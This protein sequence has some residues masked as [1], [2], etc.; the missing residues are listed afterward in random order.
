M[1]LIFYH[2]ACWMLYIQKSLKLIIF[3]WRLKKKWWSMITCNLCYY[4]LQLWKS[5]SLLQRMQRWGKSSSGST[6]IEFFPFHLSFKRNTMASYLFTSFSFAPCEF[7]FLMVSLIITNAL[8]EKL[9]V[10]WVFQILNAHRPELGWKVSMILLSKEKSFN[11]L[12]VGLHF[13][14]P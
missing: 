13:L 5:V 14:P 3:I 2:P 11:N 1:A 8:Q 6:N 12:E 9:P 7:L 4:F 10:A